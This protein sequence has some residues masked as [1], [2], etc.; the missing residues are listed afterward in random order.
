MQHDFFQKKMFGNLTRPREY[1]CVLWHNMCLH[2][3]AFVIPFNLICNMTMFWKKLN[4]DL[5]TPP[6]GSG[7][8]SMGKMFATILINALFPLNKYATWPYSEKVE[9]CSLPH[10]SPPRGLYPGLQT[11]ILFDMFHIYCT[12]VC[13]QNFS[14]NI[15]NWLGYCEI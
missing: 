11:K 3:A 13:M 10:L 14:K 7:R 8:G 12:S 5:L 2:V 6:P 15:N 1:G 9:F 4:F